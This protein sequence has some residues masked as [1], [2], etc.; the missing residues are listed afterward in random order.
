VSRIGSGHLGGSLVN[1][2]SGQL[3]GD[4]EPAAFVDDPPGGVVADEPGA[5]W[6]NGTAWPVS[7][8][9]SIWAWV[10]SSG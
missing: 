9:A 2:G 10:I 3:V 1:A 6:E 7:W 8:A 5:V 4:A